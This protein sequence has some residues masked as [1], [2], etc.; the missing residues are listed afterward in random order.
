[1][2]RPARRL[3]FESLESRQMLTVS[4]NVA[5]PIGPTQPA[6]LG[7]NFPAWDD[8][9]PTATAIT[10]IEA[11][12][13]TTMRFNG[14]EPADTTHFNQQYSGS[15]TITQF[16]E[17]VQSTGTSGLVS[18]DY[19]SGSPQEDAAEVAWLLGSPSST[20]VIGSGP[21]WNGSSWVTV[22][23]GTVGQWATLRAT[24]GSSF[25]NA[26][27]PAPFSTI[28]EFEVGNE[29]YGSWEPDHHASA[30]NA[31]TYAQFTATFTTLAKQI[32]PS[33]LV[34]I[35]SD[36]PSQSW[37]TTVMD[38]EIADGAYPGF[39]SDHDYGL[40]ANFVSRYA[41]FEADATAA[42]A[43]TVP[44]IATEFNSYATNPPASTLTITQALYV[45]NALGQLLESGYDGGDIWEF[46]GNA[47]V[48][49]YSLVGNGVG[50]SAGTKTPSY[51]AEQIFSKIDQV[52]G[53]VISATSS[54]SV[55]AYAVLESDGSLDV[56]LVNSGAAVTEPLT[57]SGYTAPATAT[58]YQYT[59]GATQL[60][61]TPV[62]YAGSVALPANS[63]T[64]VQFGGTAVVTPPPITPPPVVPPVHWHRWHWWG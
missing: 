23:W 57:L 35:G 48:G 49:A 29:E 34:G 56:L 18:V 55:T 1:M 10:D 38:D 25:L 41:A 15:E 45:D 5:A 63:I 6:D 58:E 62:A 9:L 37:I 54:G 14:G 47:G 59:S 31:A 22:N 8:A 44:V 52:G 30:H 40:D 16:A 60:A 12:G 28:T 43:G 46:G 17:L 21:E 3:R 64:V 33:V 7:V 11:A 53:Q 2:I 26:D 61:E 36:D 50:L 4:V 42:H 32:D 20:V 27:H 24:S 51:F 19:G 13:L 39:I